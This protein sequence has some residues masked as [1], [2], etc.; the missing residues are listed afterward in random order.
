MSDQLTPPDD[1]CQAGPSAEEL[2]QTRVKLDSILGLN[3]APPER[4]NQE[5]EQRQE[6][7]RR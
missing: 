3:H 2:F 7:E 5:F 4:Y 6:A 1:D